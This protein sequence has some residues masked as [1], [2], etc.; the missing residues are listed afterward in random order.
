MRGTHTE[1]HRLRRVAVFDG[2]G[3]CVTAVPCPAQRP[4]GSRATFEPVFGLAARSTR[5]AAIASPA[6]SAVLIRGEG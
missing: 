6:P 5:A 1:D 4:K 2:A 3:A